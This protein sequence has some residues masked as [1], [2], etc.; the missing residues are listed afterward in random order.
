VHSAAFSLMRRSLFGSILYGDPLG[1]S[2]EDLKAGALDTANKTVFEQLS[3]ARSCTGFS[4]TSCFVVCLLLCVICHVCLK[5]SAGMKAQSD[6]LL[7]LYED[8]SA[9]QRFGWI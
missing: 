6:A 5:A 1:Q 2:A 7:L 8:W 3:S 4:L 9:Q